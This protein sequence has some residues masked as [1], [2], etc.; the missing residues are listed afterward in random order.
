MTPPPAQPVPPPPV[1]PEPIAPAPPP[2][3]QGAPPPTYVGPS[4]EEYYASGGREFV[5][6]PPDAADPR[7]PH[8]EAE[9]MIGIPV[10]FTSQDGAVDPGVSFEARVARRFG[11]IAPE[12]TIGWQINWIDEDKLPAVDRDANI[13]IDTFFFGLGAR[14]YPIPTA[15]VVSPFFSGAFNV[16]FW[17]ITGN[18]DLVCGWYYCTTVAD[19]DATVGFEGR[20]GLAIRASMTMQIDVGAKIG[21]TF[22]MGPIDETEAWVTPFIGFNATL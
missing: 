20:L 13:T 17:H 15:T 12:F 3:P 2:P 5:A 16:Y 21:M 19:Y 22:P 18:D 1:P 9:F 6:Y 4:N 14:V 8:N 10:W 7:R 11:A